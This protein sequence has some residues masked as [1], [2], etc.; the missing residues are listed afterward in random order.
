MLG[1]RDAEMPPEVHEAMNEVIGIA[2]IV[3]GLFL[4]CIA[5]V[6]LKWLAYGLFRLVVTSF[7]PLEVRTLQWLQDRAMAR[8][9]GI[10]YDTVVA[11]RKMETLRKP[12]N[13]SGQR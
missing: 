6:I 4:V 9:L 3:G 11:R 12:M 10:D 1:F 5:F 2:A 7:L 13:P 8:T